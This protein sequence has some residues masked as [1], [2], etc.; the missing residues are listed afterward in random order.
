M[1]KFAKPSFQTAYIIQFH[2]KTA[3]AH[4]V[5]IEEM[6]A[7]LKSA[8]ICGGGEKLTIEQ[9]A[10][11]LSLYSLSSTWALCGSYTFQEAIIGS[12][13]V[14]RFSLFAA[15]VVALVKEEKKAVQL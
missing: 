10:T 12:G 1:C 4:L 14:P 2:P 8:R 13:K 7:N 5:I 15:Y 9:V 6:T 3:D 11:A